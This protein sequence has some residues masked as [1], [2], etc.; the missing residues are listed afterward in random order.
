MSKG[1]ISPVIAT[2]LLVSLTLVL[3]AIIFLWARMFIPEVIEKG[4]YGRIEEACK[5]VNFEV[6]VEGRDITIQNRGNVPLGGIKIGLKGTFGVEFLED[7]SQR[8]I[9]TNEEEPFPNALPEG[10]YGGKTL[11]VVPLLIGNLE[12]KNE[13]RAYPCEEE[14]SKSIEL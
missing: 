1:G 12:G 10:D 14:G 5:D 9:V 7:L 11:I 4:S 2:V 8:T 6:F 3:A 13:L